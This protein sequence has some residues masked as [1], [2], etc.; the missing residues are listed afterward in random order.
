MREDI[1]LELRLTTLQRSREDI[2][3]EYGNPLRIVLRCLRQ[4]SL[5]STA[6]FVCRSASVHVRSRYSPSALRTCITAHLSPMDILF[7]LEGG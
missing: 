7:A 3:E 4:S 1:D 5:A 2:G 6:A